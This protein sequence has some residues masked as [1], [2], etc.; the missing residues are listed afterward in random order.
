MFHCL[1]N[2]TIIVDISCHISGR[3]RPHFF[4]MCDPTMI[5]CKDQRG[6]YQ[7]VTEYECQGTNEYRINE[8]R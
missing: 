4:A 5:N 8:S 2:I 1:L 6:F 3:L 7:Y